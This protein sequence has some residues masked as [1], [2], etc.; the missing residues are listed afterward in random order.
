[1]PA[2]HAG[3]KHVTFLSVQGA[4]RNVLVPHYRIE[5]HLER[6]GLHH[7]LLR[8]AFFMQNLSTTH[9]ADIR[10]RDEI[11][12]PAG[13]GKT[14]FIDARDVGAIAARTL[15]ESGHDRMAYELT[16]REALDYR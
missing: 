2:G 7:T 9:A 12:L 3:L 13:R 8:P 10:E 4:E 1:M 6:S 15:T 16:G 11:F 5:R 14:A